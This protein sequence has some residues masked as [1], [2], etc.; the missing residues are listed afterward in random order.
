MTTPGIGWVLGCPRRGR[1]GPH[2]A[3]RLLI[4]VLDG[5]DEIPE[6]GRTSA[7]QS[8]ERAVGTSDR[9]LVLTCR[10]QEY[11][12]L[13]SHGGVTLRR[14]MR[15]RVQPL[16]S[17]AVI[18]YLK[19]QHWPTTAQW[20]GVFA[21]LRAD[22]SSPIKDALITPLM[23]SLAQSVYSGEGADPAELVDQSRF[24]SRQSIENHLAEQAITCA[25]L[26]SSQHARKATRGRPA[27]GRTALAREPRVGPPPEL[28][29]GDRLVASLRSALPRWSAVGVA[30]ATGVA[31]LAVAP[32]PPACSSRLSSP[33]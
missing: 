27:R 15:V 14:A 9:R 8:I 4:P 20:D 5:L 32:A 12:D 33:A 21:A 19:R 16:D 10:Q 6:P 25:Y 28:G 17:T 22:V 26:P 30:L 3:D 11:D 2:G 23:V 7:M 31:V 18:D 24:P 29:Q 1:P 13:I